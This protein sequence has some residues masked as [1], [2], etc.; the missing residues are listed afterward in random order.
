MPR[1]THNFTA[2]M[3][4]DVKRRLQAAISP[5]TGMYR[6]KLEPAGNTRSA[7]QNA[8]WF[9]CIVQPFFEF[10]REQDPV[11]TD[12]EQAHIELKKAILGTRQVP[13]GELVMDVVPA[14]RTMTTEEFSDM[15]DRARPWLLQMGIPTV[16]PDP[17]Y[18][19]SRREKQSA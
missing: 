1:P 2:D 13:I 4:L 14:S 12:P 3:T 8:Y 11:F 15:V 6:V 9:G 7:K 17:A 19:V 10:L 16:D 5:L 18:Y